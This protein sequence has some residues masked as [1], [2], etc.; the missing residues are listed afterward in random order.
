MVDHRTLNLAVLPG[1]NPIIISKCRY[2]IWISRPT[3]SQSNKP[4]EL[5]GTPHW[6]LKDGIIWHQRHFNCINVIWGVSL[7]R[8]IDSVSH[9]ICM[10]LLLTKFQCSISRLVHIYITPSYKVTFELYLPRLAH[11]YITSSLE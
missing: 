5:A 9:Q 11:I 2:V 1:L 7:M 8:G 4:T 6:S 3:W 10:A